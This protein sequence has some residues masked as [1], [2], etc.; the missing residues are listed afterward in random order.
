[1]ATIAFKAL[2]TA[3]GGPLGGFIGGAIGAYVDSTILQSFGDNPK[4]S[5]GDI[6]VA[7]AEEGAPIVMLMGPEVRTGL[8]VVWKGTVSAV[9]NT[10]GGGCG[11][12]SV[13]ST[14]GYFVDCA[15]SIGQPPPGFV[16]ERVDKIFFDGKVAWEYDPDLTITSTVITAAIYYLSHGT[17]TVTA[18]TNASPIV[19]TVA[20][21]LI[22]FTNYRLRV[23]G[24]LGN[25][26]ANGIFSFVFGEGPYVYT[27]T[28][29]TG[30]GT[31]TGGGIAQAVTILIEIR[32]PNGGPDL[33]V[34]RVGYDLTVSGY[35]GGSVANN[36]TFFCEEAGR[37][38]ATGES[39]VRLN[40][41][42]AVNTA[43]GG[44]ITLFQDLPQFS[45]RY[46][47]GVTFHNGSQWQLPD[48]LIE[49]TEGVGNVSGRRGL[50]YLTF[51][52]LN[53]TAFGDRIP[54]VNTL[55]RVATT[56]TVGQSIMACLARGG[57]EDTDVDVSTLT[58]AMR[59]FFIV[60]VVTPASTLTAIL[61]T[62]NVVGYQVDETLV[63][64]YRKNIVAT[65]IASSE[66]VA[67]QPG[68]DAPRKVR[69][70]P[71]PDR[72]IAREI[73][74]HYQNPNRDYQG[75]METAKRSG[76]RGDVV[77]SITTNVTLSPGPAQD[78][79]RRL[80]WTGLANRHRLQIRLPPS[81]I[82]IHEGQL[83]QFTEMGRTWNLLAQKVDYQFDGTIVVEGPN[84][85]AAAL[86]FTGSPADGGADDSGGPGI[87]QALDVY[88]IDVA[89]LNDAQV[90]TPGVYLVSAPRDM[91]HVWIGAQAFESNADTDGTFTAAID[92][93]RSARIGRATTAL[94]NA[95]VQPWM[96]DRVNT[97]DV[98]LSFGNSLESITEAILL[99]G[100]N[101]AML[102]DELIGYQTVTAIGTNSWR[103]SNLLRGLRDTDAMMG[104][105]QPNE[106]F[107]PIVPTTG[108]T[109]LSQ[110]I[111]LLTSTRFYRSVPIGGNVDDYPSVP[112][113]YDANTVRPFTVFDVRGDRL[114]S[115]ATPD[116]VVTWTRQTRSN[117]GP[118][119]A[120]PIPLNE[121]RE[122]YEI[123]LMNPA[124][125]S[126][127]VTHTASSTTTTTF[128]DAEIVAAGYASG[129]P[130]RVNV[131]QIGDMVGRGRVRSVTI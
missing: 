125:T 8:E 21:Y 62:F 81:R 19:I 7:T 67:H 11:G 97:V 57:F 27:E 58:D 48:S 54:N 82:Q 96:I 127:S 74:V 52:D 89:P 128:T 75:G 22:H 66:L 88:V 56:W 45:Q 71:V 32:S 2:G 36:G 109:F 118:F 129:A 5:A 103:L 53:M 100:K 90:S 69:V 131:Y 23:T 33:S 123:D 65:V 108:V 50:A 130:I 113:I 24:C 94:S 1:M 72:D 37:D 91:S 83:L 76:V 9:E 86:D 87:L 117:V 51:E 84:D 102:G 15:L 59:G 35:T 95:N 92:L 43:A 3:F 119:T 120:S 46:F 40:N 126:I 26:N 18:A 30:N 6:K 98:T 68:S 44:S 29:T 28:G 107:L 105:H 20:P 70:S 104:L 10:S 47:A 112:E 124:G 106:R 63:F 77:D 101:R 115:D 55:T 39:W 17:A 31:Y 38:A 85:E 116:V 14:Y 111:G 60:G 99:D 73:Q 12:P 78:L 110:S 34:F 41:P 13:P 16:M 64:V 122:L 121:S 42:L 4:S 114:A 61:T 79:A 25:T 80:L 93:P 49:A